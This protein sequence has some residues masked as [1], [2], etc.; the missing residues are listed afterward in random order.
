MVKVTQVMLW[1]WLML[2]LRH[3]MQQV[4]GREINTVLVKSVLT[5]ALVKRS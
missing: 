5:N 2:R 4:S 1:L 3:V